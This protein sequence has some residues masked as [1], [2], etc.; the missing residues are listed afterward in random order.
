MIKLSPRQESVQLIRK[1]LYVA[2]IQRGWPAGIDSARAQRIHEIAHIQT[3]LDI[4][5]GVTLAARIDGMAAFA[6]HFMR[7]RNIA[8]YHQIA[9][10][11]SIDD[12]VIG[13]IENRKL[14]ADV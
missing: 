3:L 13:R 10:V 6:E 9:G 8:G 14:L 5:W 11:H 4:V 1:R 12:F 7:Q 2:S